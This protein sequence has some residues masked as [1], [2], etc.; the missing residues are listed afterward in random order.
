MVTGTRPSEGVG[1]SG[2]RVE[3]K[4][5]KR[6]GPNSTGG[7][8]DLRSVQIVDRTRQ[9]SCEQNSCLRRCR[10]RERD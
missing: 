2:G 7:G 1:P 9:D 6:G 5:E 8:M 3:E 4:E 10:D